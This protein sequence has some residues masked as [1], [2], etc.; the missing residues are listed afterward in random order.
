[1]INGCGKDNDKPINKIDYLTNN[2]S[3]V[4]SCSR[5]VNPNSVTI[6][7]PPCLLDD[8]VRFEINGKYSEDNKGTIYAT[9]ISTDHSYPPKLFC[10]DTINSINSGFWTLNAKMDT[11]TVS[12][13]KYTIAGQILKLTSDSLILKRIYSNSAIQFEYFVAKK[14]E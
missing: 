5:I 7:L 11:L 4:W 6:S 1:M 14:Q 13:P 8:E 12:T 2:S 10:Q 9:T 3:K